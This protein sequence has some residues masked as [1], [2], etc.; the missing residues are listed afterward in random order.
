MPTSAAKHRFGSIRESDLPTLYKYYMSNF[1]M[2]AIAR[3]YDV[4]YSRLSKALCKWRRANKLPTRSG[5]DEKMYYE[6][7]VK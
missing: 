3:R 6:R 4:S 7:K 5:W 1:D 2:R